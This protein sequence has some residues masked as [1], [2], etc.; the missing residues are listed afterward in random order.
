L[1][2]AFE[3]MFAVENHLVQ[4]GMSIGVSV[5][6][7]DGVTADELLGNADI[8]LSRAKSEG[9]GRV[10]FFDKTEDKVHHYRKRLT[11]DLRQAIAADQLELHYQPQLRI[12]SCDL[13]GFEALLRWRHPEEGMVPPNEFIPIAEETGLINSIGEWV[14]ASACRE[15]ARWGAPYRIAVNLSPKQF[16]QA[17]LPQLVHRILLET[18]LTPSR[19]ELEV[20]ETMLFR[21][22]NRVLDILRRLKALGVTV[23]MDDYGTGY[24]SLAVLQAF[25]FDKLKIDRAF[26]EK[27]GSGKQADTIVRSVLSLGHSLDI[28]V[29]AEGVETSEQLKYLSS[30]EC[31]EVQGFYFSRPIPAQELQ[32]RLSSGLLWKAE[33]E[34]QAVLRSVVSAA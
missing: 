5:F 22:F 15:A 13:I 31:D 2:E 25:P 19:L 14:L 4:V 18:G 21:D 3:P 27:L 20:T 16:Q 23:A 34:R 7:E 11:H 33:P 10:R 29:L 26:V 32:N 28:P 17:D 12:P 24:S 30:H 1:Q 8:A 6:P 9:C